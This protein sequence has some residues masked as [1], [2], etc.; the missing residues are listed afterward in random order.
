MPAIIPSVPGALDG[1]IR[2][3]DALIAVGSGR[4]TGTNVLR[5]SSAVSKQFAV[6]VTSGQD[7]VL[8]MEQDLLPFLA[9]LKASLGVYFTHKPFQS[10]HFLN[11][12]R[13]FFRMALNAGKV[14]KLDL[15]TTG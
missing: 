14:V 1:F 5:M 4:S 11:S 15:F 3:I 8:G 13:K 12:A 10:G 7:N 6:L 2:Q 9:H